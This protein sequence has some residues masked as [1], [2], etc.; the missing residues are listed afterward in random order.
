[1][2]RRAG[3]NVVGI[4]LFAVMVFPVFWMISTAFKPDD[5]INSQTPTWFSGSPTLGH[6]RDAIDKPFFWDSVKNSIIIVLVAVAISMV[7]AFLAA[8][9]LRSTGSQ[10]GRCSSS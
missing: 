2:T 9:A 1:M 8:V 7:L 10:D 6:F 5:Q 4:V 3:W